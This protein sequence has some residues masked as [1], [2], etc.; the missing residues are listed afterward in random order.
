MILLSNFLCY[1]YIK[2]KREYCADYPALID[3][4]GFFDEEMEIEKNELASLPELY[5][6]HLDIEQLLNGVKS[7]DF[8]QG[9]LSIDRNN[10]EDG[11]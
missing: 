5:E 7:G 11:I 8:F 10:N 2:I 9:K 3:Y 1:F 4:L 6:K